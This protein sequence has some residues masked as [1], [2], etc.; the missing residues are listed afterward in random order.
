MGF[1]FWVVGFGFWVLDFGF[2]VLGFGTLD[3]GFWILG[4]GFWILG[5]GALGH[6]LLEP[7]PGASKVDFWRLVRFPNG[8]PCRPLRVLEAPEGS[9]TESLDAPAWSPKPPEARRPLN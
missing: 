1:G 4:F 7:P 6:L 2:W 9:W 3:F 5:F 8:G